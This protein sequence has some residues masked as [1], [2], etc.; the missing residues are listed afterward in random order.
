MPMH[1]ATPIRRGGPVPL[2]YA[3]VK[4]KLVI[5]PEEA[6]AVPHHLSASPSTRIDSSPD[7]GS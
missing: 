4:K 2:G 5:V 6:D 3:S 7:P 1:Q